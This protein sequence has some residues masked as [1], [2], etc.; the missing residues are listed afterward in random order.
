[1]LVSLSL[2]F[3]FSQG[4][5]HHCVAKR[6]YECTNKIDAEVQIAKLESRVR[7][8]EDIKIRLQSLSLADGGEDDDDDN[9]DD[10]NSNDGNDDGINVASETIGKR[11]FVADSRRI[12]LYLYK[13]V[14]TEDDAQKVWIIGLVEHS[15]TLV[16]EFH[17]PTQGPSP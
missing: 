14:N 2:N 6:F 4:E 11:Y 9:E 1:M 15:L 16:A 10:N 3:P 5:A 8:I 7:L 12:P 17:S 13:W